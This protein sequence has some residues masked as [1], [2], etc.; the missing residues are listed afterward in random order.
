MDTVTTDTTPRA[1]GGEEDESVGEILT[2]IGQL[3]DSEKLSRREGIS[4]VDSAI[5]DICTVA[6]ERTEITG[7]DI[8]ERLRALAEVF[9]EDEG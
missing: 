5:V 6:L 2:R 3:D 8:G 7:S 4:L 9:E 1:D